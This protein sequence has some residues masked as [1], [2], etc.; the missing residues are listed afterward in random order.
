MLF[1]LNLIMSF[2]INTHIN[3]NHGSVSWNE[4]PGHTDAA[5]GRRRCLGRRG[6]RQLPRETAAAGYARRALHQPL[7]ARVSLGT[8]RV[9]WIVSWGNR[10]RVQTPRAFRTDSARTISVPRTGGGGARRLPLPPEEE[11]PIGSP[12]SDGSGFLACGLAGL[13]PSACWLP[14]RRRIG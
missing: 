8:A 4:N 12:A 2:L 10:L 9:L 11:Q 1:H 7:L 5:S 13:W 14:A 6:R 3:A